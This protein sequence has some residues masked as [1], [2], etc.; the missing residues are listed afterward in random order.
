M[1]I[2][3]VKGRWEM[4]KEHGVIQNDKT[5][6]STIK[7]VSFSTKEPSLSLTRRA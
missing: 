4:G 7:I 3:G 1:N 6:I 5:E 2:R